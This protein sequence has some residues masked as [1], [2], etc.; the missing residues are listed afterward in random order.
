MRGDMA[1]F[2]EREAIVNTAAY[3]ARGKDYAR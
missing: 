1:S 3:L 2:A